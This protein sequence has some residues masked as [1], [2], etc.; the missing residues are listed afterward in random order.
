[1]SSKKKNRVNKEIRVPQVRVIG[2]DGE[3]V[4]I[5]PTSEALQ[6]AQ[7]QGLDLV[8]VA[9]AAKPPVCKIIDFGKYQYQQSKKARELKKKQHTIT[10]KEIKI[11]PIT[12]EHDIQFKEKHARKFLMEGD[13]VKIT[14]RFR[15]RQ[16]AHTELGREK[17]QRFI[18]DLEDIA[19]V[20]RPP[21]MEGRNMSTILAPQSSEK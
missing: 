2:A 10:V 1:M 4:G 11:T 16:L 3:Q 7:E 14:V 9:P 12:E 5:L 15:G 8:E 6:L 18:A 13:K 20:E 17:L 19:I 21:T